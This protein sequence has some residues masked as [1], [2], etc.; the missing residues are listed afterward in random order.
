M[1]Q[2][3]DEALRLK[4]DLLIQ[5]LQNLLKKVGFVYTV[6]GDKKQILI[7][8]GEAVSDIREIIDLCKQP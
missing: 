4:A 7:T 5:R 6:S 2:L 8:G 3:K 1:D